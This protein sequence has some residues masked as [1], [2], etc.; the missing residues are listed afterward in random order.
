MKESKLIKGVV[1]TIAVVAFS[2]PAFA[3]ADAGLKGRMEKVPYAD[4]NVDRKR[5]AEIL[6]QRLQQASKRVCGVES[7]RTVRGARIEADQR[8][9]YRQTLE[10]AVAEVDS[11]A[12]DAIHEG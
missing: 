7:I 12:L 5:G 11:A 8:S 4:L 9:C 1:A 10:Q 3:S 2:A 6:Y